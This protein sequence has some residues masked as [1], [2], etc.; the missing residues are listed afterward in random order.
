VAALAEASASK[1]HIRGARDLRF[2]DLDTD[3]NFI[4]IG[5]P[6]TDPWVN[7]FSDQLDFRFV[8]DKSTRLESIQN[9]RPRGDEQKF[10]V[11]TA[12]GLATGESYATISLVGNPDHTGQ[13][14]ILAG[15][16][17]EGTK[18]TGELVTNL[19]HMR[20]ALTRCGISTPGPVQHFQLLL[21]LTTMAGSPRHFDI[22][23]CHA[24]P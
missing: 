22:M 13:V 5:S 2:S 16:N 3:N 18:A 7:L 21:R 24:L 1:I 11:P 20:A 8:W 14:L 23:A 10:Y 17:A 6:R 4:F 15:A 12:K 9:V 19:D